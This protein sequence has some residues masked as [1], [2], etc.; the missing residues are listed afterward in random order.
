MRIAALSYVLEVCGTNYG[1][2]ATEKEAALV[3]R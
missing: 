2:A 3:C 1:W